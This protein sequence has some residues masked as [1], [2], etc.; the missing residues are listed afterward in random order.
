MSAVAGD[1]ADR[2]PPSLWMVAGCRPSHPRV[3]GRAPSAWRQ[4]GS[5]LNAGQHAGV[6]MPH[7]LAPSAGAAP[8]RP[9][10]TRVCSSGPSRHG[11]GRGSA[12]TARV[13]AAA[14]GDPGAW[15]DIVTR[16]QGRL[17]AVARVHQLGS[18]D[19]A[20]V[21]QTTWLRLVQ[22]LDTIRDPES[23]GAWLART[24]HRECLRRQ[25]RVLPGLVPLDCQPELIEAE[26]HSPEG[27][28]L[29]RER[30]AA[31]RRAFRRL[32][33]RSRALLALL[34]MGPPPSYQTIG[35][36]LGMRVG[37]IGPT[38]GRCLE[39]LRAELADDGLAED[40]LQVG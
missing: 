23:L 11:A 38:R 21:V 9:A 12:L 40:W 8:I 7:H 26:Q 15:L 35:A 19:A 3:P 5:E 36:A 22:H 30:D 28:V 4:C 39:R 32:P 24:A 6:G 34:T 25:R 18:A 1:A 10:G 14:A 16:F 27:E 17:L 37:S 33:P 20:D 2:R 29:L 13:R 31:L